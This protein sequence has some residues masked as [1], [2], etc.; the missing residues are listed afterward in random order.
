MLQLQHAWKER[1]AV[2]L[3][4]TPVS[5]QRSVALIV[6]ARTKKTKKN[7]QKQKQAYQC[8]TECV[9][10]R[11]KY[12]GN[13]TG[14]STKPDGTVH[15]AFRIP[16]DMQ[17]VNIQLGGVILGFGTFVLLWVGTSLSSATACGKKVCVSGELHYNTAEI[18][19]DPEVLSRRR[20]GGGWAESVWGKYISPTPPSCSLSL[21]RAAI[22]RRFPC[23]ARRSERKVWFQEHYLAPVLT[24]RGEAA[25]LDPSYHYSL[26]D[27]PALKSKSHLVAQA[28]ISGSGDLETFASLCAQGGVYSWAFIFARL[29]LVGGGSWKA[30]LNIYWLFS[31]PALL[32]FL[33]QL[34]FISLSQ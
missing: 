32:F 31:D 34:I 21:K 5:H 11:Q 8:K 4:I 27:R 3:K 33:Y 15:A 23:L 12:I 18:F 14:E 29:V 30:F 26:I 19:Q 20:G 25:A 2:K 24:C 16:A 6:F 28:T 13:E 17:S 1:K 9:S 10:L 22:R 7:Q